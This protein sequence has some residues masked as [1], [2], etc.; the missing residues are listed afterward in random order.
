MSKNVTIP[1]ELFYRMIDLLEDWDIYE[2]SWPTQ[3]E[4]CDE[5]ACSG[6]KEAKH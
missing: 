5:S 1:S 3:E 2:Y 4:Y 6:N